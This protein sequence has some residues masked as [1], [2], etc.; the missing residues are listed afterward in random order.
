MLLASSPLLCQDNATVPTAQ[1]SSS[2]ANLAPLPDPIPLPQPVEGKPERLSDPFIAR[3]KVKEALLKADFS[4]N[5][6]KLVDPFVSFIAPAEAPSARLPVGEED[7]E[8]PPEPQRPLTPLQKMNLGEIEKG[9]KAI[10]WG[11]FGRRAMVEDS[12]GKG[13]IVGVGTPVGR[14]RGSS[15]ISSTTAS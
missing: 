12:A 11:E 2:E 6:N 14:K 13:Y 7:F 15:P 10:V 8:P 1:T 5:Q 9:L 3:E 4:Y